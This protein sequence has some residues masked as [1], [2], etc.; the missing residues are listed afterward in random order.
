[1]ISQGVEDS[2]LER[3]WI[4]ESLGIELP[5]QHQRLKDPLVDYQTTSIPHNKDSGYVT[6]F[7][8]ENEHPHYPSNIECVNGKQ[9]LARR[10]A[11]SPVF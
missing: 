9:D 8:W 3:L 5:T 1:M 4:L 7:P 11:K 6:S 2:D 10:L